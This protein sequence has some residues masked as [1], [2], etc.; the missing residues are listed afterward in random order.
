MKKILIVITISTLFGCENKS[1][2][3]DNVRSKGV[4]IEMSN[5]D[6]PEIVVKTDNGI[7]KEILTQEEFNYLHTFDTIK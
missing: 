1:V 3:L 2:K 5:W 4:I 7:T 6:K